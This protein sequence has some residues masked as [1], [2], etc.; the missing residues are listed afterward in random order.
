MLVQGQTPIFPLLPDWSGGMRERLTWA[1]EVIPAAFG[2]DQKRSMRRSPRREL[3]FAVSAKGDD[4][5]VL[6]NLM[7]GRGA[8]RWLLPIWVDVHHLPVPLAAGATTIALPTVGTDY[9]AGR[10]VLLYRSAREF[11]VATVQSVGASSITTTAIT[12]PWAVGARVFPL[13]LARLSK[14]ADEVLWNDATSGRDVTMAMDEYCDYEA[15]A[16]ATLHRGLPVLEHRRNEGDDPTAGYERRLQSVATVAAL[17]VWSDLPGVPFRTQSHE[18]LMGNRNERD[19]FK[20]FIYWLE[21]KFGNVWL[22]S[23]TSDLRLLANASGNTLSVANA[24][25]HASGG[26]RSGRRDLCIEKKD[27]TRVYARVSNFSENGAVETVH[28][29]SSLPSAIAMSDVRR[30]SWMT[31]CESASDSVEIQHETDGIAKASMGFK[32]VLHEL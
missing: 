18:W 30:V 4:R 27:G 7:Q 24:A 12:R 3:S 23:G 28:L 9:A 22:A 20:K 15:T 29:E 1:T 25:L 5:A 16:P 8:D 2:K 32:E 14:S 21:G 19:G 6:D 11:E 17:P 31:L 10:K 13:R 26:I